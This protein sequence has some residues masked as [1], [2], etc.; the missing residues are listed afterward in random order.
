MSKRSCLTALSVGGTHILLRQSRGDTLRGQRSQTTS[1]TATTAT[2]AMSDNTT[3]HHTIPFHASPDRV[4]HALAFCCQF[5]P[6]THGE[7]GEEVDE[8]ANDMAAMR[9]LRDVSLYTSTANVW[10]SRAC[11]GASSPSPAP[12]AHLIRALDATLSARPEWRAG[13]T[14]QERVC[15]FPWAPHGAE[16]CVERLPRAPKDGAFKQDGG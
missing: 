7:D 9:Q 2:R 12:R 4:H 6:S 11:L 1:Q 15:A 14:R 16:G 13:D 5:I 8:L 10:S 3:P